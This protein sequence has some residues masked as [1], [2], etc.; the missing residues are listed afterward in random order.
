[1]A[2]RH[3][4]FVIGVVCALV[5][6]ALIVVVGDY[7]GHPYSRFSYFL[8]GTASQTLALLEVAWLASR[9][10]NVEAMLSKVWGRSPAAPR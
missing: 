7:A 8:F 2:A 6:G 1:L 9:L 10:S 5:C 3:C 4:G